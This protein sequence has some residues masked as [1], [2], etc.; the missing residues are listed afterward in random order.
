MTLPVHG[1]AAGQIETELQSVGLD[2][3]HGHWSR[4]FRGPQ[5]VQAIG[6]SIYNMFLSDNGL[7]SMRAEY[8][9]RIENQVTQM[10]VG[11]F[12]PAA[13]GAGTFTS[14]GS[15]SVY[16]ALHAMRE[17]AREKFPHITAP[18]IVAP[19][20]AHPSFS[21]GCHYFSLKLVRTA[22]DTS[23]RG[24]V[25]AMEQAIT[26]QT[27]GLVGS[28]PCWPFGLYDPIEK[29]G[30]L[31]AA[32]G[33]WL[34]VDACIGG[35]LAPFLERLGKKLPLWDFR[36]PAVMSIS[37]D[38]HKFGYCPKPASTVLWRSVNLLRYHYVHP[39]DWPGGQ[40]SMTGFA[41]SRSAGPIFA[42]WAVLRYLGIEGYTRLAAQV[43]DAKQKLVC[44][45]NGVPG[46]RAWENDLLPV[47]FGSTDVDL[48]LIK[49]ELSKMG[50]VLV[51]STRPPLINM[52]V[53]AATSDA[54][55][56]RFVA[57]LAR[58]TDA[59]RRGALSNRE[60]LEY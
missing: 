58:A 47:A 31:A 42:A 14:G 26:P 52:P 22:L 25:Q 13:D 53:D 6:Q 38:L 35:Y 1:I 44:G 39:S 34:H 4:A 20:S 50:W 59:A 33:L 2:Q 29:I 37:A 48:S 18:Q 55:I 11:L 32:R 40:Y 8:L 41:G 10:C 57:D 27:I 16:S 56:D 46:M 28:A 45:I 19:Y 60:A 17:W 54:I 43:L 30:A 21:K 15:E 12:N 23:H 49:A 36:V 3:I 24:S 7:F 5:D 9:A 51:G